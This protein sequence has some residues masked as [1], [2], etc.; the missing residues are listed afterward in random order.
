LDWSRLGVLLCAVPLVGV[1][2]LGLHMKQTSA[3]MI[4]AEDW[5]AA[6]DIVKADLKPE[7]LVVF[8]PFWSD[9][10]GRQAFGPEIASL[11]RE[12]RSDE[13]RF[14]RAFEV[15]IRGFHNEAFAHWK[16]AG[17]KKA[18]AI[19]ITT[20]ENPGYTKV[21][22][23]VIDLLG[24]DR[25]T[26]TRVE[27][28]GG[29][30]P[31]VYQHGATAGG[32][33]VVP[34]GLL[35]PASKFVCSGGHVGVAVLHDLEHHPRLCLYATPIQNATLTL[36]FANVPFGAPLH[37]HAGVHWVAD[38]T[39]SQERIPLSFSANGR[40]LGTHPHRVGTGWVGFELP[41]EELAGKKADL[42]IEVGSSST[43]YFC[44]EA[45]TREA[46]TALRGSP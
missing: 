7:D 1:V 17:E 33:T 36:K 6:R 24:T 13:Q 42:V 8:E 28:A 20:Y 5:T 34:Q 38:R 14:A 9:P 23:D 32:S 16:K 27:A 11:K 12:G 45:T 29:E 19:T 37:G 2:E 46:S 22:D 4:P 31:C 43:H 41:T 39:P 25:A 10:L 3:D 21:I 44:F 18:G 15:S 30:S 35:T 40:P 26:V